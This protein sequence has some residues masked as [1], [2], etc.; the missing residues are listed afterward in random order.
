MGMSRRLLAAV[1]SL[2]LCS[3]LLLTLGGQP[4]RRLGQPGNGIFS[5]QPTSPPGTN[6]I[7]F[8]PAFTP[9]LKAGENL[10]D[11]VTVVNETGAP[12]TLN[13]YAA[14]GYTTR[15]GAFSIRPDYW[16]KTNMGS[17]VH[18]PVSQFH[19]P[20]PQRGSRALP[21]RGALQYRPW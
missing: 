3:G 2:L 19:P 15:A 20:P 12:L 16:P 21:L 5:V 10:N 8:R 13:L 9:Q 17:W 1:A 4:L 18:L 14:N 11:S 7:F 6:P